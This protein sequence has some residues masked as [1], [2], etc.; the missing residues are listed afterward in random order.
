M[1]LYHFFWGSETDEEQFMFYADADK[2]TVVSA[3]TEYKQSGG[4]VQNFGEVKHFFS[5]K[6]IPVERY[7]PKEAALIFDDEL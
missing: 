4:D 7:Y 2:P 6:G 5:T 3:L 1:E